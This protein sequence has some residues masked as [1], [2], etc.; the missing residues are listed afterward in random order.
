MV[1]NLISLGESSQKKQK[2]TSNKIVTEN[3][4]DSSE[5]L[6]DLG[7]EDDSE[8]DDVLDNKLLDVQVFSFILFSLY[9]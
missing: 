5:I 2:P 4:I 9:N 1:V 6:D 8:N 7:D 3:E